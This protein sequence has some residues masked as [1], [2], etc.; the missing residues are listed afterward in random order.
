MTKRWQTIFKIV[1]FVI[2]C[3]AQPFSF[4]KRPILINLTAT[5]SSKTIRKVM[6]HLGITKTDTFMIHQSPLNEKTHLTIMDR[7][8]EL[9]LLGVLNYFVSTF[10]REHGQPSKR[11]IL[12]C[13][14]LNDCGKL[15][16]DIVFSQFQEELKPLTRVSPVMTFTLNSPSE[17][18]AHNMTGQTILKLLIATLRVLRNDSGHYI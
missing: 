3:A 14:S 1:L 6:H 10:P 11:I 2:P 9:Y 15:H 18:V 4:Q 8:Q 16:R 5:L 12:F 7:K 13:T 17:I